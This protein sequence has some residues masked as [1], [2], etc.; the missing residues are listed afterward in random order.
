MEPRWRQRDGPGLVLADASRR[1]TLLLLAH[2]GFVLLSRPQIGINLHLIAPIVGDRGVD[3]LQREGGIAQCNLLRR[4][5]VQIVEQD[6]LDADAMSLYT[7]IIGRQEI[8]VILQFHNTTSWLRVARIR[9]DSPDDYNTFPLCVLDSTNGSHADTLPADD[10]SFW[11]E[12]G[13]AVALPGLPWRT[14]LGRC[15][16]GVDRQGALAERR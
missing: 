5:A 1:A 6:G 7:N 13:L 2:P 4:Q 12:S 3:F 8:K 16:L 10:H 9:Q 11:L 15:G 14:P